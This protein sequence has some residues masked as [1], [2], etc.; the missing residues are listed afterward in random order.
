MTAAISMAAAA[1][2]GLT[3]RTSPACSF[4]CSPPLAPAWKRCP[5]FAR[6]GGGEKAKV[7]LHA[8]EAWRVRVL[9]RAERETNPPPWDPR[10]V[11]A[12]FLRWLAGLSYL[13]DGPQLA[14]SALLEKGITVIIEPRLNQTHLDG[15]ALLSPGGRPVIG[16]TLRQDRLDNFW[17]TLF[18][19]LGHVLLHLSCGNPAIFDVEI[20]RRRTGRIEQEA[21]RLR[22]GHACPA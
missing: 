12:D 22:A 10:A 11:D 15:S 16:L 19:E 1:I 20:D 3:L 13:A 5:A 18:H 17:F 7:N 2:G 6:Q 14:C 9:L 21:D 4:V 8:L